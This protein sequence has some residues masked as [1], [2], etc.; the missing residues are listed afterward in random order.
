MST[1][2][3]ES[4]TPDDLL[5]MP[6]SKQ[7]ELVG[8]QLV[9]R[10]MG[11]ESDWIGLEINYRIRDYLRTNPI[12]RAFG[13]T[14]SYQCFRPDRE[15]VRKPDGSFIKLGRLAEGKIPKGHIR[16]APDLAIEVISPNDSYID[17]DAKIHEYLDAGVRLV[18]V[19]NPD[20][21]TVKVYR[22]DDRRPIE[23]TEGDR[24]DGGDVLPGFTCA[25]TDVFPPE[26]E[27]MG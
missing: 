6:D 5:T 19:I 24:L 4:Y 12:G 22:Q 10:R 14:A 26:H 8:G 18:W 23:L 1:A 25:V 21:R 7:Y 3:V 11:S 2:Q 9:E 17:V 16:V 13:P 15:Q 20:N 27:N